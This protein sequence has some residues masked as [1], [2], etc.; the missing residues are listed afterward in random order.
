[1]PAPYLVNH[2]P[3]TCHVNDDK[4]IPDIEDEHPDHD[5]EMTDAQED[6]EIQLIIDTY[7]SSTKNKPLTENSTLDKKKVDSDIMKFFKETDMWEPD[8]ENDHSVRKSKGKLAETSGS[9]SNEST[10]H[11]GYLNTIG[12]QIKM[13]KEQHKDHC[14][15]NDEMSRQID[16]L[17]NRISKLEKKY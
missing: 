4:I 7:L 12:S 1:M 10:R 5:M 17:T 13:H 9:F 11:Q 3:K 14:A 6:N 16:V 2:K 15:I 8:T